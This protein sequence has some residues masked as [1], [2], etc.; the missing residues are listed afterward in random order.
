MERLIP[1][2][3]TFFA[4]AVIGLAV[5]HFIFG[6]FI[7][8]RAPALSDDAP[9]RLAWA[10]L[11]GSA[12]AL[13]GVS[14][15]V[16]RSARAAAIAGALL[17]A[18]WALPRHIGV[19]AS[20]PFLSGAWTAAGKALTLSTG[21]LAIAATFHTLDARPT[22]PPAS[23]RS[24]DAAFVLAGR[25][26]LGLFFV[27]TGIQHFLFTTFVA[28]LIPPWFPG[29]AVAWT[30]FAGVA[31][32]AGGI[33][34]LVPRTAPLAGLLSG[35]MVFSWFWIVHIPRTLES[36]SDN[37]AVFEALGV[38]GLA[39]VL[40]GA[41]RAARSRTRAPNVEADRAARSVAGAGPP[42]G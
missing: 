23:L 4:L 20:E 31:L 36:V 21:M 27:M 19:L 42:E 17:I 18:G 7:T 10:Y 2:G 16:G 33:G 3:R 22:R 40:S 32:V 38:S 24:A 35:L 8:G 9:G 26:S 37:I 28:S 13:I 11:S 41:S 15:L 34:L 5:E 30:Y 12:L 39:L 25:I 6:E 29:N 1:P 14:I